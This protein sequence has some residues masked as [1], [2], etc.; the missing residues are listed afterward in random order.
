MSHCL[1]LISEEE[2]VHCR[3]LDLKLQLPYPKRYPLISL[4]AV[5]ALDI[6]QLWD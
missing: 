3:S 2:D 4:K 6:L 1:L 5:F